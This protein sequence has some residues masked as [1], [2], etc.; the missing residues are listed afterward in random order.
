MQLDNRASDRTDDIN[1]T[2]ASVLAIIYL[3]K[4]NP[5][6]AMLAAYNK[7]PTFI[8]VYITEGV[9]ES[10]AREL[11]GGSVPEG[12][13]SEALQGGLL[14]LGRTEKYF[15]LVLKLFRLSIQ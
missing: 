5:A 2:D 13:D 11:L 14:N 3:H 6:W 15:L 8:P 9:V 4:K 7:T 12:A 10:V 1:E